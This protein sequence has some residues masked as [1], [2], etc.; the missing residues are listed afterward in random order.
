MKKNLQIWTVIVF[1]L[2]LFP[3]IIQFIPEESKI[4]NSKIIKDNALI[5]YASNIVEEEKLKPEPVPEPEIIKEVEMTPGKVLLYFTHADEAYKPITQAVDGKITVNH[6]TENVMKMGDKLKSS[7]EMNG[8]E[9]DT[10]KKM[11]SHARAYAE[12]RPYVKNR[13]SEKEYDLIIDIHRDSV[14]PDKTTI[15][16]ENQK[17]AKVAFVLGLDNPN[18]KKNEETT[19]RLKQEMEKRIPGITRNVISKGGAGVDG[20]Y[21]QDLHPKLILVELGGVGNSEDELNRTIAVI[22]EAIVELLA[23]TEVE[24]K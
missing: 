2:F 11:V 14:G 4:T 10:L 19:N 16:H 5:V 9:T 23:N 20:K 1:A 22:A 15:I 12:I 24:E 21:N 18:Y 6:Q 3:V 13:L 7:L 17:Y 8:I